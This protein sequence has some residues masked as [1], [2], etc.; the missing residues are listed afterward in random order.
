MK[1]NQMQAR[2]PLSQ[3]LSTSQLHLKS[4]VRSGIFPAISV[5]KDVTVLKDSSGPVWA[6]EPKGTQEGE[7]Y[8]RS[9]S[10]QITATACGEPQ[11]NSGCENHR[12]LAT[13]EL[14]CMWKEW[15]QWAQTLAFSHMWKSPKFLKL[16]YLVI[17]N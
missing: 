5:N 9:N 1:E 15:F 8:L 17:F 3:I 16:G 7:E 14:R 4:I 10:H 12:I 2:F 11:G 13:G 6:G